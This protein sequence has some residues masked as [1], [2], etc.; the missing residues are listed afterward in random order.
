MANEQTESRRISVSDIQGQK[1]GRPIV[2]LT[3]YSKP[4][5]QWLDPHVDLLLVG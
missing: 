2:C 4:M 1:G 3:A 5:A